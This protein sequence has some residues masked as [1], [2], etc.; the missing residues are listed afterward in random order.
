MPKDLVLEGGAFRR[1][2]GHEDGIL[3]NRVHAFIEKTFK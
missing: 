3:M 2:L 1:Y